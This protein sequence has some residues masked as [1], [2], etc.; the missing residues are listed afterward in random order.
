M[1]SLLVIDDDAAVRHLFRHVFQNEPLAVHTASSAAAGLELA[2]S[3]RPDVVVI[4]IVLPD[5]SGLALMERIQALDAKVPVVFITAG[6]ASD[7][8]I[9]AMKLGAFDYLLKPLDVARIR[10]LV[11]RSL[12]I[13]NSVHAPARPLECETGSLAGEGQL[14]GRSPAMQKV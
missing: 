10:E 11:E 6:G 9:E 12:A 14:V 2:A 4:D 3:E 7:T 1:P 5:A 8:A 13:R